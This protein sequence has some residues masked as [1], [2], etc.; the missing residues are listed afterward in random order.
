M[1]I[2]DSY[3]TTEHKLRECEDQFKRTQN[4][5]IYIQ[6]DSKNKLD[7]VSKTFST[8]IQNLKNQ[9]RE[10]DHEAVLLIER[11]KS[12]IS[13]EVEDLKKQLRETEASLAKYRARQEKV[14]KKLRSELAKT[15]N[16]LKK[17]KTNLDKC[18]E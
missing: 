7:D 5:V 17:T 6:T 4:E 15:H 10:K 9:L 13:D 14:D 12:D 16:V 2:R 3:E 11:T 1:C 8:E 18:K